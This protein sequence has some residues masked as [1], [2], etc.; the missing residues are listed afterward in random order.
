ME[1]QI[2]SSRWK[3]AIG[4]GCISC[5]VNAK[6][7]CLVAVGQKKQRNIIDERSNRLNPQKAKVGGEQ[8]GEC[9]GLWWQRTEGKMNGRRRSKG[10]V[11]FKQSDETTTCQKLR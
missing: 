9:G 8:V 11:D 3:E 4:D 10:K 1:K 6:R 7:W 2:G 5:L